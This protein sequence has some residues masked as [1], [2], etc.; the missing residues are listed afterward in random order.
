LRRVGETSKTYGGIE[1][2]SASGRS[3]NAFNSASYGP[4]SPPAAKCFLALGA[5][6]A[7]DWFALP[8]RRG[9]KAK[10]W[11]PNAASVIWGEPVVRFG[12]RG[13]LL[14]SVNLRRSLHS[15]EVARRLERPI[16]LVKL[17]RLM[18]R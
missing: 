4:L 2:V 14:A 9:S 12:M 16:V 6:T 5:A 8:R 3:C 10:F 17:L 15:P 1:R 11:A 18:G 13:N 7:R